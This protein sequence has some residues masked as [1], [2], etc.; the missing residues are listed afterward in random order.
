MNQPA[1]LVL[2][3]IMIEQN[4]KHLS[5]NIGVMNKL[6]VAVINVSMYQYFISFYC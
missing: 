1:K 6:G 4:T 3:N 2:I 5:T